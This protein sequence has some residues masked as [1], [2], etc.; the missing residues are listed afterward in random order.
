LTGFA[1]E[2]ERLVLRPWRNADREP[3]SAMACDPEVMRYLP[4]RTRAES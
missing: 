1:I 4:P 3:F 2:T